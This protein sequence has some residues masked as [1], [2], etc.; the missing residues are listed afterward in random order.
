MM[1][2]FGAVL[3]FFAAPFTPSVPA[4]PPGGRRS[5]RAGARVALAALL[6][7]AASLH[8]LATDAEERLVPSW[9]PWR[10][11]L[12]YLSGILEILGALGLLSPSPRVRRAAGWGVAALLIAVFPANVNHA[13]NNLQLGGFMNYRPYQWARLPFQVVFIWW[14]L[15]CT[16]PEP[17]GAPGRDYPATGGS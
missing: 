1:R 5:R 6:L 17:Q 13:V 14:A 4:R 2:G 3:R 16:A 9:L 10:R 7:A 11:G 15:W 12:V 8:F